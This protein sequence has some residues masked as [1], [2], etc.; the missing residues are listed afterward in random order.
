MTL[1]QPREDYSYQQEEENLQQIDSFILSGVSFFDSLSHSIE[2]NHGKPYLSRST[3]PRGT[4]P[5]T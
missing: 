3:C 5:D 1:S 4:I 2:Y